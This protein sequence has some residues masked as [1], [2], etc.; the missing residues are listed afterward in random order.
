[1]LTWN[2]N[3]YYVNQSIS[4]SSKHQFKLYGARHSEE[5]NLELLTD[6]KFKVRPIKE[7]LLSPAYI[8]P[9]D[10]QSHIGSNPTYIISATHFRTR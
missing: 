9:I 8:L 2:F 4:Q 5:H 3:V 6:L 10:N 1:M 7:N